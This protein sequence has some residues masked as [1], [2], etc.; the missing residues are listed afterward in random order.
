MIILI[1]H[2]RSFP[3]AS[4]SLTL[5]HAQLLIEE[6]Q[7][8]SA[9]AMLQ[10]LQETTPDCTGSYPLLLEIAVALNDAPTILEN[11]THLR[12]K[13]IYSETQLDNWEVTAHQL[14]LEALKRKTRR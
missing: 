4:Q 8:E 14:Q 3:F 11:V 10:K 7:F 12:H 13:N 1:K 9:L 5:Q 6:R 2:I